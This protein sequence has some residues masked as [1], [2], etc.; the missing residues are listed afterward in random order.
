MSSLELATTSLLGTIVLHNL[1]HRVSPAIFAHLTTN[2]RFLYSRIDYLYIGIYNTLKSNTKL[3]ITKCKDVFCNIK[4]FSI[5]RSPALIMLHFN[6]RP[7]IEY[8][9]HFLIHSIDPSFTYCTNLSA[10]R[11]K[12]Y[13]AFIAISC[14]YT[15]IYP[16]LLF[17]CK[18]NLSRHL[19]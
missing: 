3:T 5:C 6:L 2:F 12:N 18:Q 1:C 4:D 11:Q 16:P 17:K 14:V 13:L 7:W 8:N 15:N 10:K 9:I 19:L